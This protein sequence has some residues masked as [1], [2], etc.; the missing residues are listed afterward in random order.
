MNRISV[1]LIGYGFAGSVF[2]AP[3]I[4]SVPEL[5]LHTVVT[6]RVGLVAEEFSGTRVVSTVEEL[7]AEPEI[8]LVVVASPT[9]LHFEHGRAALMAGKH[10]VM[11]KPVATTAA[12]AQILIDTAAERNRL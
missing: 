11:D 9:A 12:E 4:R 3:L 10:V 7:L 5:Q 2:H 1:G 8:E 6:S